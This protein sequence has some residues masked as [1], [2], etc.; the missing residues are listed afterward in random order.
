MPVPLEFVV[1]GPPVSQQ[2]RRR[3]LVREWI[4]YVRAAA[5][6][7]WD[8]RELFT[9]EV[10][11]TITYFFDGTGLDVDNIP[12]PILDALTGLVYADDVQVSDL[13]CRKRRLENV[14]TRN[15]SRMVQE[16]IGNGEPFTHILVE[17]GRIDE[18]LFA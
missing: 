15:P 1:D 14:R 6:R 9:D 18:V 5:Q 10:A 16:S 12:K 4:D 3:E 11:V 13:P 7:Y 2:A 8:T 17:E